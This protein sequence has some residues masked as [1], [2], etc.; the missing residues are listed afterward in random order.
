MQAAG[1]SPRRSSSPARAASPHSTAGM[2]NSSEGVASLV[3]GG[4][5]VP[6]LNGQNR[7]N[8]MAGHSGSLP[9]AKPAGASI[10]QQTVQRRAAEM[11]MERKMR[12]PARSVIDQYDAFL[13]ASE[14][15]TFTKL[16]ANLQKMERRA[17]RE[18]NFMKDAAGMSVEKRNERAD[19]RTDGRRTKSPARFQARDAARMNGSGAGNSVASLIQQPD[20]PD[21]YGH[22]SG[23]R[24]SSPRPVPRLPSAADAEPGQY[25][26]RSQFSHRGGAH[27]ANQFGANYRLDGGGRAP[28][29]RRASSPRPSPRAQ[30][31]LRQRP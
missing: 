15:H 29:P 16:R 4:S 20:Q 10:S 26:D 21:P 11:N 25:T 30:S 28:S 23:G 1:W 17:E 6:V 7:A 9:G 14:E 27:A 19:A 2:R 18:H 12:A 24:A 13:D 5:H 8:V 3:F 31:P 22:A